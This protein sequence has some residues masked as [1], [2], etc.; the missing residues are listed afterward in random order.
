MEGFGIDG[1][2][3]LL[4]PL[5]RLCL[6]VLLLL[7]EDVTQVAGKKDMIGGGGP[8]HA[9]PPAMAQGVAV[10]VQPQVRAAA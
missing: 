2:V 5:A 6:L 9:H 10:Q 7:I 8:T 1:V 4:T 3:P